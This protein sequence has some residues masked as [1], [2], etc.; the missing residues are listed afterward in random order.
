MRSVQAEGGSGIEMTVDVA[1]QRRELAHLG[2]HRLHCKVR[3]CANISHHAPCL[4]TQLAVG[5]H[6][7]DLLKQD[8]FLQVCYSLTVVWH[9]GLKFLH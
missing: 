6:E 2:C 8:R 5:R 9:L 7:R 3:E 4:D 1:I